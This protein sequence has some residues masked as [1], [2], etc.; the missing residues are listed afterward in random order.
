MITRT[1]REAL[2]AEEMFIP[3]Y[4]Y[5]V[6]D[7]D[8]IFYVGISRDPTS[9]LAQH[10]GIADRWG[11]Y[12]YPPRKLLQDMEQGKPDTALFVRSQGGTC[13]C[14][15]AP[16]SLEWSFD[17]YE[18]ADA[19]AVLERTGRMQM[20]PLLRKRMEVDWYEQ[21]SLVESTLIQE[22]QPFLNNQLNEHERPIP[23][24]YRRQELN[25]DDNAVDDIKL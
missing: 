13:I 18:K 6:R 21:R 14:E 15:N 19:I 5:V 25:L 24:R 23:A 7:G 16:A 8:V 17:I 20:Y 10:V 1:I 4:V 3:G 11:T 12:T 22:L 9:R 2:I